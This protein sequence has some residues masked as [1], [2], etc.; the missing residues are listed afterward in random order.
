MSR[1]TGRT[2]ETCRLR[3]KFLFNFTTRESDHNADAGGGMACSSFKQVGSLQRC[4][5]VTSRDT[6]DTRCPHER[7]PTLDTARNRSQR[8]GRETEKRL[9]SR[10]D[11]LQEDPEQPDIPSHQSQWHHPPASLGGGRLKRPRGAH[12]KEQDDRCE[13]NCPCAPSV[14]IDCDVYALHSTVNFDPLPR[15]QPAARKPGEF[16]R[17]AL[18]PGN[19]QRRT[20]GRP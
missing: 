9:H 3:R 1:E 18:L 7:I 6:K 2:V 16:C 19:A 8:P 4:G 5:I 13:K 14:V 15:V 12:A 10:R 11:G 20:S 17:V